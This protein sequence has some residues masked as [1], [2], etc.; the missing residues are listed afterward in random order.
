MRNTIGDT[1]QNILFVGDV[2]GNI[3]RF[4][5]IARTVAETRP[6]IVMF[7][8]D[9]GWWPRLSWG[10][11]FLQEVKQTVANSPTKFVFVDG[12]HED[13][14]NLPHDNTELT[15][16]LPNLWYLPRGTKI[17]VQNLTFLGVGG[18][19]S[20]D[21]N[22][23]LIGTSWFQEETSNWAQQNRVLDAG[24]ADVVVAHDVPGA[25]DIPMARRIPT[26]V[27]TPA[28]AHRAFL[29]AVLST[30]QP[31][32]WLAGHYHHRYTTQVGRTKIEVLAGHREPLKQMIAFY[33]PTT[34]QLFNH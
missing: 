6:Q 21:Q 9:F 26:D 29:D 11:K 23:R 5:Q 28:D 33:N 32:L 27:E 7:C 16:M 15:E 1:N 18:A 17:R 19:V 2:H 20:I 8:G 31:E 13:H 10:K 22:R 30:A 3:P 14:H 24:K 34:K 25:A 4:Q 12:N